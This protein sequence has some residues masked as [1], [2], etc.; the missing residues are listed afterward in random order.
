MG[1]P[2]D[3]IHLNTERINFRLDCHVLALELR[4]VSNHITQIK[5]HFT[6][7]SHKHSLARSFSLS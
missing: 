5:H 6:W 7:K 2:K 4:V 1:V 3:R